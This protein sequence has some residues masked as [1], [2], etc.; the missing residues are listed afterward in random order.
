[1]VNV[2]YAKYHGTN[3]VPSYHIIQPTRINILY[4]R[5]RAI[6]ISYNLSVSKI[7]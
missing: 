7:Y 4:I 3:V 2:K 5:I 1:M 6:L